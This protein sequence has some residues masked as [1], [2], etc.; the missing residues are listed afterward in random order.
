MIQRTGLNADKYL[1]FVQSF[2]SKTFSK[3]NT[4]ELRTYLESDETAVN[5]SFT[6]VNIHSSADMVTWG[7]LAPVIQQKRCTHHQGH[8]R[9]NRKPR[10]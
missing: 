6:N 2:S 3:D 8:Q 9:D 5:N 10:P 1:E 7:S 4:G